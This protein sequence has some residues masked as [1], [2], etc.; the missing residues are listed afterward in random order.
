MYLCAWKPRV[1]PRCPQVVQAPFDSQL[2]L[3]S[4][5]TNCG[6]C[7]SKSPLDPWGGY[8]LY[9]VTGFL[10]VALD[11][12]VSLCSSVK[13]HFP[14]TFFT[15]CKSHHF[16][17][18]NSVVY[19]QFARQQNHHHYLVPEHFCHPIKKPYTHEQSLLSPQNLLQP[20]ETTNLSVSM[21][22]P[23]LSFNINRLVQYV[24][25]WPSFHTKHPII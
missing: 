5:S 14:E 8:S 4:L 16:K 15:Y 23:I 7:P 25:F 10:I 12:S 18:Y 21:G 19:S 22:L 13:I 1:S 20:L 9:H 2:T 6:K 3:A 17:V 11:L 24:A